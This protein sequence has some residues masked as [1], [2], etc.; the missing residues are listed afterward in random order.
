MKT[1]QNNNSHRLRGSSL[2]RILVAIFG[3]IIILTLS[4][5][6][7]ALPPAGTVLTPEWVFIYSFKIQN[8]SQVSIRLK[9]D[10]VG[11]YTI[12]LTNYASS[13]F[14]GTTYNSG[15]SSIIVFGSTAANT[16]Y[17]GDNINQIPFTTNK[18]TSN[19]N[20]YS[21]IAQYAAH[22]IS[23]PIYDCNG[24]TVNQC[25]DDAYQYATQPTSDPHQLTI[26]LPAGNAIVIEVGSGSNVCKLLTT[27]FDGYYS[28]TEGLNRISYY[29]LSTLPSYI[30]DPMRGNLDWT[31][32]G[33][34]NLLNLYKN[35]FSQWDLALDA[36]R[37]NESYLMIINPMVDGT[38]TTS[39]VYNPWVTVQLD[40][41]LSY[42]IYP[43]KTQLT[44]SGI[45]S[46][47]NGSVV[48]GGEYDDTTGEWQTTGSD[49]QPVTPTTGGQTSVIPANTS[50]QDWLK[51]I[52]TQISSFFG[53]AIDSI[54]ILADAISSFTSSLKSLYMW[55]PN[56]VMN[57]VTS[58]IIISLT[59]GVI[60]VFI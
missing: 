53:G 28:P 15:Q 43:L 48:Y 33:N 19:G 29:W 47:N 21:Q 8:N 17:W 14:N 13:T 45:E 25:L 32:Y 49:G 40:K 34:P 38:S 11:L 24:Q 41:A 5:P 20:F 27:S 51:N 55:L 12:M 16:G 59:I 26:D 31:G 54:R 50:V 9:S 60:K 58:A 18:T 1:S 22:D 37:T 36:N 3:S 44:S 4:F 2:S 46:S 52:S 35:W 30:D 6:V 10:E 7:F 23:G 56:P 39:Q 42:N 57:V